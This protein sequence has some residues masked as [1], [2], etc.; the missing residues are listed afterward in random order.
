MGKC[1]CAVYCSNRFSKGS[2]L[3]FYRFPA[4]PDRRNLWV[5]AVNRKN[6]QPTQYSWICSSHFIGGAKS[7][8]PTSPS[9]SPSIFA[10]LSSCKRQGESQLARYNRSKKRCVRISE[11]FSS[12][13]SLPSS[14]E[15]EPLPSSPEAVP[16]PMSP[17]TPSQVSHEQA[18]STDM[19]MGYIEKLES[20][21]SSLHT[22]NVKDKDIKIC[23]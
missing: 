22:C 11:L 3:H 6:W 4:D 9:Y 2:G 19:S 12:T 20:D 10:H 16:L 8:D 5:A 7:D 18:C 13:S 17:E 1:C 23:I 21:C 15:V 14:P